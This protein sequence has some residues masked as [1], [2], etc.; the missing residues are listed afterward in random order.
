[1]TDHSQTATADTASLQATKFYVYGIIPA[2]ETDG[3][4]RG[5]DIDGPLGK[6][7]VV[8]AGDLAALVSTLPPDHTPG[9]REDLDAH[10][11]VLG[12]AVERGTV[13]PLRFGMVMDG[14]D[15]VRQQLLDRHHPELI[16][17]LRMLEDRVQ[18]TIRALYAEG[19][20]L[21]G[22][23]DGDAEIARL[24]AAVQ[25]RSEMESRRERIELGERVAAAV[26]ARREQDEHVLLDHLQ[27]LV[28][29]LR[30]DPGGSERVAFNAHLLIRRSRRAVL[31]EAV[32]T[33]G[34]QLDGYL[35]LRYLGPLPPY[36]FSELSLKAEEE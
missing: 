2:A 4:R 31:D 27:P 6:V 11:H 21:R 15:V 19:A 10:R 20:L 14:E 36:S 25:G 7:R 30:V 33:L 32:A 1:M 23:I 22:A 12:L 35:A 5:A 3:W 18:M 29:D 34:R 9:R 8:E 17:L 26:E 24:S 13:I 28:S 16:G